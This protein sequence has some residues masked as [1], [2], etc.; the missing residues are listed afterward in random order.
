MVETRFLGVDLG[1]QYTKAAGYTHTYLSLSS[2]SPEIKLVLNDQTNRKSPSCVALRYVPTYQPSSPSSSDPTYQLE[3]SFAE[4]ADALLYRFP[5]QTVCHPMSLLF[6]RVEEDVEQQD[7]QRNN[8]ASGE[9]VPSS[10]PAFPTTRR[11]GHG[12]APFSRYQT[13]HLMPH[14]NRSAHLVVVPF[15]PAKEEEDLAPVYSEAAPEA[16]GQGDNKKKKMKDSAASAGSSSSSSSSSSLWDSFSAEELLSMF[17]RESKRLTEKHDAEANRVSKEM[18]TSLWRQER[19]KG[20]DMERTKKKKKAKKNENTEKNISAAASHSETQEEEEE[21]EEQGFMEAGAP[22]PPVRHAVLMVPSDLSVAERQSLMDAGAI[23][24]LRVTKLLHSTT[25]AIYQL[26]NLK[27]EKWVDLLK[28][29]YLQRVRTAKVHAK[30]SG[31]EPKKKS[32]DKSDGNGSESEQAETGTEDAASRSA[33]NPN[34]QKE[35]YIMIFEMGYQRAEATVFAAERMSRSL[36]EM[37]ESIALARQSS[38]SAAA[39]SSS[40]AVGG[41]SGQSREDVE[42]HIRRVVTETDDTLGGQAFDYC[43]A[44]YWDEQFLGGKVLSAQSGG[45]EAQKDRVALLRAAEQARERLSVNQEA[46]VTVERLRVAGGADGDSPSRASTFSTVLT[47]DVFERQCGGLFVRAVDLAKKAWLS[48][49]ELYVPR[50][51]FRRWRHAAISDDTA[52]A[53]SLRDK[54][55]FP[56]L[57]R[58]DIIGAAARMPKLITELGSLPTRSTGITTENPP[59]GVQQTLNADESVVIGG[60]GMS[61][62]VMQSSLRLPGKYWVQENLTNNIYFHVSPAAPLPEK[63]PSEVPNDPAKLPDD[64]AEGKDNEEEKAE[65]P[66]QGASSSQPHGLHAA[67]VTPTLP[68]HPVELLFSKSSTLLPATY[69]I[70]LP[71]RANNFVFSLYSPPTGVGDGSVDAELSWLS[72]HVAAKTEMAVRE[73]GAGTAKKTSSNRSAAPDRRFFL[74]AGT[75]ARHYHVADVDA[76]VEAVNAA[77]HRDSVRN[78][79]HAVRY[80][81][82]ESSVG[83]EVTVTDDGIPNLYRA[84]LDVTL[85][86]RAHRLHTV[87]KPTS[88]RLQD[89]S[90][91]TAKLNA[92]ASDDEDSDNSLN[93]EPVEGVE[94]GVEHSNGELKADD[95][96]TENSEEPNEGLTA[97]AERHTSEVNA[98]ADLQ[99]EE[100]EKEWV[101][102]SFHLVNRSFLLKVTS[103]DGGRPLEVREV[104]PPSSPSSSSSVRRTTTV[105]EVTL[106]VGAN[107]NPTELRQSYQRLEAIDSH[108][109]EQRERSTRRNDIETVLLH[110]RTTSLW[111]ALKETF[112]G[113]SSVSSSERAEL[114]LTVWK[115]AVMGGNTHTNTSCSSNDHQSCSGAVDVDA[116]KVRHPRHQWTAASPREWLVAVESMSEWLEENG[117]TADLSTLKRQLRSVKGLQADLR[118]AFKPLNDFLEKEREIQGQ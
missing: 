49:D 43:I 111:D 36:R 39:S 69:T 65:K 67:D 100:E 60:V 81:V 59:V 107:M 62:A 82:Q 32:K 12:A 20:D 112:D 4:P 11:S 13:T 41:G 109:A 44:E 24:G 74:P 75:Y 7:Q 95:L 25:A 9:H 114:M 55:Y 46:P 106:P 113:T 54:F 30:L 72:A 33:L 70:Q 28:S 80:T 71:D 116:E 115:S 3:R 23:S 108:E 6:H 51:V 96:H 86:R 15:R 1:A 118:R 101:E 18:T 87:K 40:D 63:K 22:A 77:A 89:G 21:E 98:T 52:D 110:L 105:V 84:Y 56:R 16:V 73:T 97:A 53:S 42:V 79:T 38:S 50:D 58:L 35:V 66:Q 19:A 5:S 93:M 8:A 45:A 34:L 85:A 31:M 29:S 64:N 48:V 88:P 99:G 68:N 10:S 83:V 117:E 103:V 2:T 94:G 90:T 78:A 57:E 17:L 76:V 14:P 104:L 47:R 37:T 91:S 102:E 27:G 61:A 92:A 26:F